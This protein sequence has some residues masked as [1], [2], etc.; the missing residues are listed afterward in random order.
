M[1]I[2]S[3]TS[4]IKPKILMCSEYKNVFLMWPLQSGILVLQRH[5]PLVKA[6]VWNM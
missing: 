4:E 6:R 1:R 5:Q 3:Q 2:K